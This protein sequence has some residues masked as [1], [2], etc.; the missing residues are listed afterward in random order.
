M[1]FNKND[2]RKQLKKDEKKYQNLLKEQ[3]KIKRRKQ[4]QKD[5]EKKQ[6][7]DEL[8][9]KVSSEL[10]KASHKIK[11]TQKE[12]KHHKGSKM[13]KIIGGLV[14][15]LLGFIL[16]FLAFF[17]MVI[18][19][20]GGTVSTI[21]GL[22]NPQQR[23]IL[24]AK[25]ILGNKDVVSIPQYLIGNEPDLSAS[26]YMGN[27]NLTGNKASNSSG[28]GSNGNMNQN[29]YTIYL[30]YKDKG[31]TSEQIAGMLGCFQQESTINFH[32]FEGWQTGR[33]QKL[34]W[35]GAKKDEFDPSKMY[36][37][38][39]QSFLHATAPSGY[40]NG[41]GG[42]TL[43]LGVGQFTG[44]RGYNLIHSGNDWDTPNNQL[45]WMDTKDKKNGWDGTKNWKHWSN[46]N[47]VT[48]TTT[49][50]LSYWEG[51]PGNALAIR[52]SYARSWLK[53]IQDGSIKCDLPGQ[54]KNDQKKDDQK[55]SSGGSVHDQ[56]ISAGGTE[57]LWKY[58]V[59]PESSGNPNATNGKYHGLGQT[60]EDWGTGSVEK[61]TKGMINYAKTRY[62][63][64]DNAIA[65]RKAHNWW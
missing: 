8:K 19:N 13:A 63:S 15:F 46:A 59:L 37:S 49:D 5:P 23:A 28:G 31:L 3:R 56:F 30:H 20:M 17:V 14:P 43:G 18:Y 58:I 32:C 41:H 4:K 16:I 48:S 1:R 55:K 45:N 39:W 47:N 33:G 57:D 62:G 12:I 35:D 24:E 29:A 11:E 51:N 52:L 27:Q 60:A 36:G 9:E 10:S 25:G 42:M 34:G 21:A 44:P 38:D 6:K 26:S 65:F 2:Y 61:Q 50:F 22:A 53:K 7:L 40:K 54:K 64:I